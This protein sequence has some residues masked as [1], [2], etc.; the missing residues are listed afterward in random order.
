VFR[1]MH[2]LFQDYKA[3]LSAAAAVAD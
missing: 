3:K 2:A 1:R